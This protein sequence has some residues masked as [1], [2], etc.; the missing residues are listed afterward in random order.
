MPR[1]L[2]VVGLLVVAA[3]LPAPASVGEWQQVPDDQGQT[4]W[5]NKVT[6]DT[7]WTPPPSSALLHE[8]ASQ[9]SNA[10]VSRPAMA[11][12]PGG[13]EM[14]TMMPVE[15]KPASMAAPGSEVPLLPAAELS[16]ESFAAS[17][18]AP[19]DENFSE[20]LLVASSGY[21]GQDTDFPRERESTKSAQASMG[22]PKVRP[23]GASM[24]DD[25]DKLHNVV[26]N[27]TSSPVAAYTRGMSD[28]LQQSPYQVLIALAAL[29]SGA[30][31]AWNGPGVWQAVFILGVSLGAA[32]MVRFELQLRHL[33]PNAFAEG[34]L[35]LTVTLIIALAAHSGFEGSQ[36]MLGAA[37]GFSGAMV[38]GAWAQGLDASLPGTSLG[39]YCVGSCIG[40]W[41][42][43]TCRR[44]LLATM[45]PLLGSYLVV[46]SLG[47]MLGRLVATGDTESRPWPF[48]PLP[49][50]PWP[51]SAAVLLGPLG[52]GAW[53]WH[54]LCALLAALLDGC[55]RRTLAVALL[56]S[57]IALTALGGLVVGMQCKSDGKRTDG[58]N[59]PSQ[60]A[61]IDRWQW[62]LVGCI[63]WAVLAAAAGWRQLLALE[64]TP[65]GAGEYTLGYLSVPDASPNS[66]DSRSREEQG[67]L[68]GAEP[69]SPQTRQRLHFPETPEQERKPDGED[70][71][72]TKLP[73]GYQSSGTSA[74][75]TQQSLMGWLS[76]RR[77][78]T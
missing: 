26:L 32:A 69:Q 17:T 54:G 66:K 8:A 50:Q 53:P 22:G 30:V 3:P 34:L 21:G 49:D 39:W 10:G 4:L 19:S 7:S 67:N 55:R 40:V 1:S 44:P 62:Q 9:S 24:C 23:T 73:A 64:S 18:T 60:F 36:V 6:G 35:I 45:G 42:F 72:A 65:E 37:L 12:V 78:H 11:V 68:L 52:S 56:I 33:A 15:A 13:P 16:D 58:S 59:C 27:S 74:D 70:P 75:T 46:A 71:F 47:Y 77:K 43:S 41:V 76:N 61:A 57:Y 14:P 20:E 2:R 31:C 28:W 48:L 63:A 29:L 51:A 25:I 5:L 38:S